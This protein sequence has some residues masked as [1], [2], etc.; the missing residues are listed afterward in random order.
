MILHTVAFR[1]HHPTGSGAES[2]FLQA[3]KKLWKLPGVLDFKV[4]RQV[5]K[6][7]DFTFGLSMCFATQ[8]TYDAYNDHPEH[9]RFVHDIWLKQVAD[10]MEID[11]VEHAI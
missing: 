11:Y 8:A 4:Y 7:N 3:A 1:L 2:E 9:Q 5:S 10:F 6:K